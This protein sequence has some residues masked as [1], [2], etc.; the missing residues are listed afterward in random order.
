MKNCLISNILDLKYKSRN[1]FNRSKVEMVKKTY[2][3]T[4]CTIQARLEK[5]EGSDVAG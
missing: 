2:E 1:F 5:T 4:V 3:D